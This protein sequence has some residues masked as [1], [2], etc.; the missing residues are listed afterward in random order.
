MRTCSW[1][2]RA[3]YL[4]AGYLQAG[5]S[6]VG[7]KHNEPEQIFVPAD[8]TREQTGSAKLAMWLYPEESKTILSL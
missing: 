7:F 2:L 6:V 4:R 1:Y 8:G 3:G 5:W